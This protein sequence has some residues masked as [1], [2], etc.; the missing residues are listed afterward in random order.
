MQCV[1]SF[2]AARLT[3]PALVK[4]GHSRVFL[5]SAHFLFAVTLVEPGT[6]AA[7]HPPISSGEGLPRSANASAWAGHHFYHIIVD[8]ACLDF[9]KECRGVRKPVHH[10]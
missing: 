5:C 7:P 6:S 8:S 1:M 2:C 4:G 3:Q 10:P 9:L